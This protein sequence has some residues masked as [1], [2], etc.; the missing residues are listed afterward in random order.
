[1]A[2]FNSLNN[3]IWDFLSPMVKLISNFGSKVQNFMKKLAVLPYSDLDGLDYQK[4]HTKYGITIR[5]FSHVFLQG[6][7]TLQ[8]S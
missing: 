1:M 4:C 2:I 6:V 8:Y 5:M 3:P 7:C